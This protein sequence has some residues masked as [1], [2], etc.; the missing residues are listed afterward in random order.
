M[1]E[2]RNTKSQNNL[3]KTVFKNMEINEE[4]NYNE[5]LNNVKG[6]IIH[7]NGQFGFIELCQFAGT[8]VYFD[9]GSFE[10]GVELNLDKVAKVGDIVT[11]KAKRTEGHKAKYRAIKVWK[12]KSYP[13]HHWASS[14]SITS[15]SS[16]ESRGTETIKGIGHIVKLFPTYGYIRSLNRKN[17]I[18]FHKDKVVSSSSETINL[19]SDIFKINDIVHFD[20]IPSRLNTTEILHEATKVWTTTVE[21]YVNETENDFA[22]ES[23]TS[24]QDCAIVSFDDDDDDDDHIFNETGKIFFSEQDNCIAKI[25]FENKEIIIS[26]DVSFYN[27]EELDDLVW[28]LDEGDEVQ[29]DAEFQAD[30]W[31]ALIVW[32]GNKPEEFIKQKKSKKSFKECNNVL[33]KSKVSDYNLQKINSFAIRNPNNPK[34][35]Y[36]SKL[37]KLDSLSTNKTNTKTE[38]YSKS[39]NSFRKVD[40]G[41]NED[42][43]DIQNEEWPDLNTKSKLNYDKN[44][45]E[46]KK[47]EINDFISNDLK[48]SNKLNMPKNQTETSVFLENISVNDKQYYCFDDNL[49]DSN[50]E[51]SE[52]EKSVV[53]K[54]HMNGQFETFQ[55]EVG[56]IKYL[57]KEYGFLNC[58]KFTEEKPFYWE[59]AYYDG[60]CISEHFSGLNEIFEEFEQLH[61][62]YLRY[63]DENQKVWER[64]TLVWK[65]NKPEHFTEIT[66][67]QFLELM[68]IYS[69]TKTY[70]VETEDINS[71]SKC[72]TSSKNSNPYENSFAANTVDII[73]MNGS[74][75]E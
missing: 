61:F 69:P 50:I 22:S 12:E 44:N 21:D 15:I 41:W 6:K 16:Q 59:D 42:T 4:N 63:T 10:N 31:K 64:I 43:F 24:T 36:A 73:R 53:K 54:I 65:G 26:S 58:D 35:T 34:S 62:N 38:K 19:L 66:P 27:N 60:L 9:K 67:E 18:F 7:I 30:M 5:I 49:D 56:K 72:A 2:L 47:T 68:G 74:S 13:L 70:S 46:C 8:T 28:A 14:S 39:K 48:Y 55:N 32:K 29:F 40:H 1:V 33:D 52:C 23:S 3:L 57:T 11:V 17:K 71:I 51:I 37:S 20:A 45:K 25:K 75:L